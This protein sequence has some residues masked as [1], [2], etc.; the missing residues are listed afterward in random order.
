MSGFRS[1]PLHIEITE[2]LSAKIIFM[3]GVQV[4]GGLRKSVV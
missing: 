2:Y 1:V 3:Y 4:N